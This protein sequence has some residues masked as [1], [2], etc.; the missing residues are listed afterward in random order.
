MEP[1][2]Y[3]DEVNERQGV[4]H[5]RTFLIGGV[6]GVAGLALTGRLLELQVAEAARYQT[7]ASQNQFRFRLIP[8]PRGRILDR[9]GVAIASNRPDFRLL[10]RRDEVDDAEGLIDQ[11]SL[12]VP[13]TPARRKQVLRDLEITPRAVPVAVANDL[14]WGEFT[15]VN[16][17][18]PELPGVTADMGESRVYPFGGAFAHVIGYVSKV[19]QP[20]LERARKA[21]PDGQIDPLLLHPGF[22]I[23]KSGVEQALDAELRGR[24]GGQKIEVD[25]VGRVIREDPAGDRKPTPG[26][27]VVLTL[28]ADVQNRAL[29][30]FGEDSGAAVV[31]DIHTGDLLCL[32]SAP[33]FDPNRFVSGVAEAEYR[34][35]HDYDHQPLLDKSISALYPPGST[36]NTM[37]AMAALQSGL[38]TQHDRIQCSGQF[39][40]GGRYFHCWKAHGHGSVDMAEAIKSSCDVYFYQ[41][42]LR[43]G[44]DRIAEVA[45]AF[46]LGHTF[47][48][49]IQGQRKGTVPSTAWKKRVNARNPANQTWFAGESLSYG[50][51]QGAL[52]VNALQLA[53]M[54][55]RLANGKKALLPRLIKSVGGVERPRGDQFGDLPF[56]QERINIVREA[57]AS[58]AND[59]GGTA[60]KVSQLNL[61]DIKMAGKTGSAQMHGYGNT[62]SGA[63]ERDTTHLPWRLR[64]HGL[65]V[66]FAPYDDPRYAI[67][68]ILE[69]GLH[70]TNAAP[71]AVEIMKVALLKDPDMRQ[72]IERPLPEDSRAAG[73]DGSDTPDDTVADPTD[74]PTPPAP[75]PP[76]PGRPTPAGA[77]R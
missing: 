31:I 14:T 68:V 54:T 26:S 27:D 42:A 55:A 13:V 35:L 30:V 56:P 12:L 29:E 65:F 63:K 24:P 22:R 34:A 28:D 57:M 38:V 20:D 44:P 71:K 25:S 15:R 46:G 37:T 21:A 9:N 16:A 5:R 67:S 70:G 73:P 72:R 1:H 77:R 48:I 6:L 32:V 58:V 19:S 53:V 45:D 62:G 76:A 18:L 11:I 50:I 52:Q 51:G 23:G 8:P 4:F 69:H 74:A 7:M 40:Y 10:V 33:S 41:M 39:F 17:R 75:Q 59:V 60:F 66:A 36:Y 47:D 43:I 3:F 2:I 64:D 49:G 61:G